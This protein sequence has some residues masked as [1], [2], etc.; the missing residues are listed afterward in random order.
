MSQVNCDGEPKN[1]KRFKFSVLPKRLRVHMP[2]AQLLRD[3]PSRDTKVRC[4]A[5][6]QGC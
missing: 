5:C 4:A 6:M 1:A 2:K 3:A